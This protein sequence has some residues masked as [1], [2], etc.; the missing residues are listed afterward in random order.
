[1][2][3]ASR[4][5]MATATVNGASAAS[6]VTAAW[7]DGFVAGACPSCASSASG[8]ATVRA[9]A[10]QDAIANRTAPTG[11]NVT[12]SPRLF[13]RLGDDNV[14]ETICR[15]RHRPHGARRYAHQRH[16]TGGDRR[17]AA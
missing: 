5:A 1:M 12:S 15:Q 3:A 17:L 13:V 8:A 10:R 2:G 4:T 7:P 11:V 6:G 9:G 14:L 16:R